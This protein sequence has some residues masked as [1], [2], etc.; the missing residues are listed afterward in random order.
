MSHSL[1]LSQMGWTAFFQ[2][3]LSLEDWEN[4]TIA[5]VSSLHRASIEVM[6]EHSINRSLSI[7]SNMTDLTVGDWL[8][9]DD[10]GHVVRVLERFSLFSRKAAGSKVQLQLIAANVNT[11]FVVCALNHNFNLN[12]I[13]RYL[14]LAKEAQVEAVVVLTNADSCEDVEGAIA[15]VRGLDSMLMVEAVNSLDRQSVK[16]IEP[17]CQSGKTVAFLGSSGVG[18]STLI[19]T[20]LGETSQHTSAARAQDSRGRHTTTA[21]SLHVLPSGGLLIDTPGMRE[22]QLADCEQ[23][24]EQTFSEISA[25]AQQCRFND[26]GHSTEP[27][28]AVRAAIESGEITQRRFDNYQKLLREQARNNQTLAEK[29]DKERQLHRYYRTVLNAANQRKRPD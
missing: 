26:C 22:L 21:R 24:V 23:G 29:R 11:V 13:E 4:L 20:L 17:W 5:R 16:A 12:R 3:Q 1:S 2:Q 7:L 27:G 6:T 19:N 9:C 28:C 18:K 8:L 10:E 25:L 14:A 15:Q